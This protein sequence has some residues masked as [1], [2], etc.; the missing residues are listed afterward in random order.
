MA[1]ESQAAWRVIEID[2]Y[3]S[4]EVIAGLRVPIASTAFSDS[5]TS[6]AFV[7]HLVCGMHP[8]LSITLQR[9]TKGGK[10][11]RSP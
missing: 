1:D 6:I 8:H 10:A 7:E 4:V 9:R 5:T 11:N 2:V 3:H